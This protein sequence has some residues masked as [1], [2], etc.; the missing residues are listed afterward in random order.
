M[1][2]SDSQESPGIV[3]TCYHQVAHIFDMDA[4]DS[5]F[6]VRAF[7]TL[8]KKE[9]SFSLISILAFN[10]SMTSIDYSISTISMHFDTLSPIA[11]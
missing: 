2:R 3:G 11:L 7:F 9:P 4:S 1:S 8:L 5:S 10:I 6:K